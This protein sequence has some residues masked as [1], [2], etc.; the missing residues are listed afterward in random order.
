MDLLK[1]YFSY[2]DER[3]SQALV[4]A[5]Y[6]VFSKVIIR[7]DLVFFSESEI[8]SFSSDAPIKRI[9]K[10]FAQEV[11]FDVEKWQELSLKHYSCEIWSNKNLS[12]PEQV[13]Y[14]VDNDESLRQQTGEICM[15]L[16]GAILYIGPP[17]L[18]K[19]GTYF[20]P[21]LEHPSH[22]PILFQMPDYKSVVHDDGQ[23]IP[24]RT[25]RLIVFDG[26]C[27]HCIQPF[28]ASSHSPRV[29]LLCNI[30]AKEYPWSRSSS[31]WCLTKEK[32]Y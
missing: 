14:H 16:F 5:M 22:D 18:N 2:R 32:G 31:H 26:R 12:A 1:N 6:Q 4:N 15:P 25:S 30:W 27:P 7:S 24:F 8:K 19:G 20:N 29:A 28:Q 21:P 23:L 17:Q 10:Q 11:I 3:F 9:L 13:A